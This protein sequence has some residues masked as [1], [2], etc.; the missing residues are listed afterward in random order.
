MIFG[1]E[2]LHVKAG[3]GVEPY[4]EIAMPKSIKG[5]QKKWFYLKNDASASLPTVTGGHPVLLPSWGEGWLGRTLASC[6]PCMRTF[7]NC[8]GMG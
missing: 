4:L 3:H 5:W 2:V 8:D 1:G 7:N 6:K